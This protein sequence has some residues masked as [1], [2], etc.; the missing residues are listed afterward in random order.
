MSKLLD[1]GGFGCVYYNPGISCT[2]KP[3]RNKDY[4][5]KLQKKDESSSNEIQI[6]DIIK[7]IDRYSNVFAPI[8]STCDINI[9]QLNI[10]KNNKDINECKI[11]K[12]DVPYTLMKVPYIN[13]ANFFSS[14]TEKSDNN[15][16]AILQV[17]DT[18]EVILR[19]IDL[20]IEKKVV[21]NDIKEKNILYSKILESPVII[22]FGISIDMDKLLNKIN[23]IEYL[24]EIFYVYAPDYYAWPLE[25]HIISYLLHEEDYLSLKSIKSICEEFVYNNK[26][27]N[28]YSDKFK[29]MY[30]DNAVNYYKQYIKVD[31]LDIIEEL[32]NYWETWDNYALCILN[33]KF[34]RY[35]FE[36]GFFCNKFINALSQTFLINCH[37]NPNKRKS[38]VGSI[39]DMQLIY[40]T[41][42]DPEKY[43]D[44]VTNI[45]YDNKVVA[46]KVIKDRLKL[47]GLSSMAR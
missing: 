8:E 11:I 7:K 47:P 46:G 18:Y 23:D 30:V 26:G 24:K 3:D 1:A 36:E 40:Y 27:F 22:D 15:K 16:H 45:R 19:A 20:L 4:V 32:V 31:K 33:L 29:S 10:Q 37:Y 42:D 21:H 17:I 28:L 35:L 9:R 6:S 38:I 2:G 12:D 5:T 13:K 41:E 25:I 39:S 44:L 34:L 14:L 43:I